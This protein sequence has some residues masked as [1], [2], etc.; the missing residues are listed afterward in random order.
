MSTGLDSFGRAC[1]QRSWFRDSERALTPVLARAAWELVQDC[2]DATAA[3]LPAVQLVV[4]KVYKEMWDYQSFETAL[5]D[6]VEKAFGAASGAEKQKLIAALQ[7]TYEAAE[8]E[9]MEQE[10]SPRRLEE[11]KDSSKVEDVPRCSKPFG[12]FWPMF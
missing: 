6:A 5:R 12:G 2:E 11:P 9:A 3:S 8:K 7:R 4:E 10:T 1:G